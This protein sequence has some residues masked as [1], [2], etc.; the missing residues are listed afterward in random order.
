ME[1]EEPSRESLLM[2][3]KRNTLS[4]TPRNPPLNTPRN[5]PGRVRAHSEGDHRQFRLC[6]EMPAEIGTPKEHP[7]YRKPPRL[8]PPHMRHATWKPQETP[9]GTRPPQI[10]QGGRAT[11]KPPPHMKNGIGT[12]IETRIYRLR[13]LQGT[14][15]GTRPAHK[16]ESRIYRLSSGS[17]A[18]KPP[19]HTTHGIGTNIETPRNTPRNTMRDLATRI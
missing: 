19:P 1:A 2:N 5:T 9:H 3:T 11:W 16:I 15:Q 6:L 13:K 4:N 8:A 7:I 10:R 17:R 14:P 12:N 18:W